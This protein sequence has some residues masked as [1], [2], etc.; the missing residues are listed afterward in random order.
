MNH[1]LESTCAG[2]QASWRSADRPGPRAA[3]RPSPGTPAPGAG[4][5]ASQGVGPSSSCSTAAFLASRSSRA[6]AGPEDVC[7]RRRCPSARRAS[8]LPRPARIPWLYARRSRCCAPG[9]TRSWKAGMNFST[10]SGA[11]EVATADLLPWGP[12]SRAH[13]SLACRGSPL[14]CC[15]LALRPSGG[16][17]FAQLL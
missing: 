4:A 15:L 13:S 1:P 10:S 17:L 7:L 8:G 11:I 16:E 9:L 6:A 5:A 3:A 14:G 12:A 2:S